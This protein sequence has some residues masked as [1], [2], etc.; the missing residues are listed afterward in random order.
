MVPVSSEELTEESESKRPSVQIGDPF[1]GEK[2]NGS[3]A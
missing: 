1:V 3:N 2:I